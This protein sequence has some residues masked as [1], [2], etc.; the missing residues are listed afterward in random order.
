LATTSGRSGVGKVT[1]IARTVLPKVV[2]TYLAPVPFRST[3]NERFTESDGGV[4][5]EVACWCVVSAIENDIVVLEEVG[6]V[7]GEKRL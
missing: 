6:C 5:E 3:T 2:D 4:A 1:P 7:G